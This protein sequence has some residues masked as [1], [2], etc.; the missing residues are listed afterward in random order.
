MLFAHR[1]VVVEGPIGAGKTSLAR[2]IA[3]RAGVNTM[4][5]SP[6]ENPFLARFYLNPERYALAA[7]IAFLYQRV[8][9]L[10]QVSPTSLRERP[11]VADFLL[12]KDM[13]FAELTLAPDEL[14]L[15]RRVFA[16]AAPQPPRPDLVIYLHATVPTLIER[17]RRRACDYESP[18]LADPAGA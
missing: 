3:E 2:R 14:A 17:V 7:Q 4:L 10:Q 12:E 11:L 8:D 18:L 9:Q 5:E 13:L 16:T 15:Y 1:F 6:E